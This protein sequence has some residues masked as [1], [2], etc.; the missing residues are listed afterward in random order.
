M[1]E[2]FLSFLGLYR[3]EML[4]M[5]ELNI[6]VESASME[7]CVVSTSGS[8][9]WIAMVFRTILLLYLSRDKV[10]IH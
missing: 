7:A 9:T 2:V 5:E 10:L 6:I 1:N 3:I 8:S 4:P